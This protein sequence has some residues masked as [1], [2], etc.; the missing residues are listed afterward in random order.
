MQSLNSPLWSLAVIAFA[1]W[2]VWKVSNWKTTVDNKLSS[3]EKALENL[4]GKVDE[5]Y[6]VFVGSL[7]RAVQK[8]DSPVQLSEYG[9]ALFDKIDAEEIVATYAD[10]M[11]GATQGVNAYQAQEYCFSFCKEQLL[12][13]LETSN[14]SQFDKMSQVA[15]DEGIDIEKITRGIALRGRVIHMKGS[16]MRKWTITPRMTNNKRLFQQ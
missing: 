2:A 5:V 9:Q 7:G 13:D 16:R 4:T 3:C 8:V 6:R 10:R 1:I 11:C 14:K 15:F 12:N